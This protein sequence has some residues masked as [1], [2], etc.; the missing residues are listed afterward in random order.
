MRGRWDTRGD[1]VL[2]MSLAEIMLLMVFIVLI[3]PASSDPDGGSD[4]TIENEKLKEENGRLR[5]ENQSLRDSVARLAHQLDSLQEVLGFLRDMSGAAGTGLGDFRTAFERMK[6]GFARCGSEDNTLVEVFAEEGT[7]RIS[8]L[9]EDSGLSR[10]V[11]QE[12]GELRAG[13][14]LTDSLDITDFLQTVRRYGDRVGEECRFDYR[15]W[16]GDDADYRQARD[17][18]EHFLY[19]ERDGL[20]PLDEYHRPFD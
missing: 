3:P 4:P 11:A 20:R 6:R 14:L 5:N 12:G 19:P 10:F 2:G 15:L 18:I 8:I 13:D 16:Y 7:F 9:V 1:F 17:S